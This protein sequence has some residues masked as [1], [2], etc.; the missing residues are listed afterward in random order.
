MSLPEGAIV[1]PRSGGRRYEMGALWAV[2]KANEA[3]TQER[4]SVS[5]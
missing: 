3:E 1:L 4:Y 5:E 2:F